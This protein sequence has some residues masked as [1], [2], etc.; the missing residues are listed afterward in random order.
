MYVKY[1]SEDN[2]I[3][4]PATMS[5]F[6][7]IYQKVFL[8]QPNLYRRIF[9]KNS[10]WFVYIPSTGNRAVASSELIE[11]QIEIIKPNN[12]TLYVC[13]VYRLQI[14][15]TAQTLISTEFEKK[16]HFDFNK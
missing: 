3:C 7:I 11:T 10:V 5:V 2:I 15:A 1:Q 4:K 6:D 14:F 12:D 9:F 16:R 8:H 13:C